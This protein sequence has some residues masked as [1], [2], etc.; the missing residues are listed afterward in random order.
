MKV[1]IVGKD[2]HEIEKALFEQG[3]LAVGL[4]SFEKAELVALRCPTTKVVQ[5]ARGLT[6]APIVCIWL[7]CKIS[8]EF[9]QK[10]LDAGANACISVSLVPEKAAK[11]ILAAALPGVH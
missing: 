5:A 1:L 9:S 11:Q 7:V 2:V 8:D 3:H 4:G 10:L 6:K